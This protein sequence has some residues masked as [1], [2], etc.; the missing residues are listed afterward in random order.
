MSIRRRGSAKGAAPF[1]YDSMAF[2]NVKGRRGPGRGKAARTGDG[3]PVSPAINLT[4]Q[5]SA[6]K[7]ANGYAAPFAADVARLFMTGRLFCD[8]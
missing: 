3:R 6:Q 7:A 2:R 8:A 1:L 5:R 4:L